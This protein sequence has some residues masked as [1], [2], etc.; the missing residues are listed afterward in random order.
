MTTPLRIS[1][2]VACP[3]EHAFRVWTS[4]IGTWWPPDH[5]VSGGPEHIVLT[6]GVGGRIYERS[7]DGTEHEWG[8]VTVWQPPTR[9]VYLWYLGRDRADAT[10]VEI[11][12]HPQGGNTRVDIEH[13]GWERAGEQWRDRTRIGWQ[14]LLPHYQKEIAH[15][16]RH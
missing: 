15:G 11:R 5:T 12:F 16:R 9:L 3:A 14:T 8:E 13:R 6:S 7:A 10:E 4:G 2:D 1:F